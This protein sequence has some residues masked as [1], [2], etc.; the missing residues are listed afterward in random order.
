VI[1]NAI[2][3]GV[4]RMLSV[5]IDLESSRASVA[6][7]RGQPSVEAAVGVHPSTAHTFESDAGAVRELVEQGQPCAI[8]EIG[9]DYARC[10]TPR[11]SQKQTFRTQLEWA[12][13]AD[14][15]VVVHNRD[16]H[17]DVLSGLCD[18]GVRGVLHCFSGDEAFAGAAL[19]AGLLISFAGNITYKNATSLRDVAR[20][21]PLDRLLIE[22]DSPYLP[23]E[24]WRGRRNE[25]ARVGA[26]AECLGEIHGLTVEEIGAITT[27]NAARLFRW[28][29]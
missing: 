5:G 29:A 9:L 6:L 16:A 12:A 17:E 20:T 15:P 26:V 21:V 11:E 2:S 10:T 4:D 27:A 24:G 19:T 18:A 14:L 3:V 8:G 25:P 23:P 22:T 13:E 28:S 7:A 1:A